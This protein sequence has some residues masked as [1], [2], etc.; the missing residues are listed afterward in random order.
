M[1]NIP[2]KREWLISSH[3]GNIK[4][5]YIIEKTTLGEGSFGFVKLATRISDSAQRAI[6]VIPKRRVK[7]PELLTNEINVMKQIDHPNIIQ[8]YE[9][10][11]DSQYIYLVLEVCEGGELFDKIIEISHFSEHDACSLFK[12]VISTISYLHSKHIV[13][14]DLKPENFLF[15]ST[16]PDALLK[17]IDFGFSRVLGG[18]QKMNSRSG[19]CYYVAPEVY[20]GLE[21]DDKCDMWSAG[22][23]L[24]MMLAGYAPFDGDTEKEILVSAI[25]DKLTFY[26][27]VWANISGAAKDLLIHLIDKSPQTRYSVVEVL[28][29]P[30]LRDQINRNPDPL[31]LDVSKLIQYQRS[32]K[33]RRMILNY[34]AT[35]CSTDE[36]AE[37]GGLFLKL[38]TN[39]DGTLSYAEIQAALNNSNI[40]K[41]ELERLI[42]IIDVNQAGCIDFTE[43]L[44]VFMDRRVYM[45]QEKL[46]NA[47]KRFDIYD[48]GRITANELKCVL[49][50]ENLVKDPEYWINI[51]KE[52]DIDGDGTLDFM[53]FADMMEQGPFSRL[54]SLED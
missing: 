42:E 4:D 3:G 11:E 13:H 44:A 37:I 15:S 36:I 47:F 25:N 24:Y 43:F 33:F 23:I 30:W 28:N 2:F 8:L 6:K 49:D 50:Q 54:N 53:E 41:P 29:H 5:C 22:V 35:Q 46:W 51:I 21:Y 38:D 52:A 27:R 14:R 19:T 20:R 31:I 45:C 34:M 12:Q 26:D 9:T 17:L 16:R 1:I 39:H 7:R 32:I 48:S 18:S 10:F 40:S